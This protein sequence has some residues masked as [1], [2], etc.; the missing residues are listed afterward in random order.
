MASAALA[1]FENDFPPKGSGD[2]DVLRRLLKVE[3]EAAALVDEAQAEA[4]RRIA[5]GEKE[6]RSRYEARYGRE[7]ERLD[8]DYAK[9]ILAIKEQYQNQLDAYRESLNAMPVRKDVF[10]ALAEGLL[11]GGC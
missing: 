7:A 6:S 5:E 3:S 10:F 4:D 1:K 9:T 8:G 2:R 11:F